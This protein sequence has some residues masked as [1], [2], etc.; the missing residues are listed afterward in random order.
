MQTRETFPRATHCLSH[1]KIPLPDGATLA[2]RVWLPVDADADPVPAIIDAVPYRL[3]DGFAPR[4]AVQYPYLAG[5]GYAAVRIDLR[6][7]GDSEGLLLDEYL[8]QELDDLVHAIAWVAEQPWCVG[9]V[10][11]M[12]V[13]WGGTNTL[14]VAA[15]RPPQLKAIVTVCSTDDRYLDDVHYRGGSM[16]A[17]DMASWGATMLHLGALPPHPHVAGPGWQ[18]IWRQRLEA[19]R[20]WTETW[21]RHQRRDE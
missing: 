20:D 10:G 2:A 5:H 6:G 4:D 9:T 7:S 1:V 18:E 12:G 16:L 14:L 11:M 13:S 17:L 19:G 3:T 21:L 15:R 8:P